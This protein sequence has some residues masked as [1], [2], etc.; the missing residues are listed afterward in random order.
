[1]TNSS[2]DEAGAPAAQVADRTAASHAA[3]RTLLETSEQA[4][5]PKKLPPVY[6]GSFGRTL[7]DTPGA[8][9]GT[10]AVVMPSDR[11]LD[12]TSQALLRIESHPDARRYIGA[13]SAGP[14]YNPDG[15]SAESTA[16]VISAVN[17]AIGMPGHHGRLQV[18]L[19]GEEKNGRIGPANRRPI[20][21]SPV[22]FG[23]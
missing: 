17:G 9:D 2:S 19:L 21:N 20:P 13:V 14:F 6:E 3:I 4:G 10:V 23:R 5:G 16:M 7:Y 12:V 1:M 11:I 8:V 18:Q 15:I 22:F